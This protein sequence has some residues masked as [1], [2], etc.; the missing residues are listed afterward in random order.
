MDLKIKMM[1][2]LIE[3]D[4]DSFRKRAEMYFRKRPELM[5]LVEEF[6]RAYRALAERY[7]HAT[8]ALHQ[9]HRTMA[10]AFP[11]QIPLIL[12]DESPPGASSIDAEPHTLEMYSHS[13]AFKRNGVSSEETDATTSKEGSWRSTTEEEFANGWGRNGLPSQNAEGKSSREK[14]QQEVQKLSDENQ[15]LKNQIAH[16][17]ERADKAEAEVGNLKGTI[18]KLESEKEDVSLLYK[19]ALEKISH[20]TERANKAEAE[21]GYLKGTISKLNSEREDVS[22]QYNLAREMMSHEIERAD[23]AEAEVGYLKGTI[24]KLESEKED[25]S[26]QYQLALEKISS[27]EADISRVQGDFKKL[28]DEMLAGTSKSRSLEDRCHQLEIENQSLQLEL[29]VLKEMAKKQQDE[30]H[31]AQGEVEKLNISINEERERS[32]QAEMAC[33]SLE[34]L[35]SQSQEEVRGLS[36]EIQN[37]VEK[38]MN[39]ELS[40]VGLEEEI[41]QLKGEIDSLN[42]QICSSAL[43]IKSLQDEINLLEELK[44]KLQDEVGVHVD[45]KKS[46]QQEFLSIKADKKA[47]EQRHHELTEQIGAV[48]LN[49]ESLQGMV[50][51]LRDGNVEL[52]ELCEKHEDE[53][54]IY[55][56]S[57]KFMEKI[58]E[59]NVALENSLSNA[60]VELEEL[61]EKVKTLEES[62]EA[63][64]RKTSLHISEKAVIVSQIEAIARNM[65]KLSEKNTLLENSLSDVNVELEGLRSK[66]NVLEDTRQSLCGQNSSLLA[67]KSALITQVNISSTLLLIPFPYLATSI[68]FG[69]YFIISFNSPITS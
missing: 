62:C 50:K 30:L 53:R 58:T 68:K 5:R 21:V 16:E 29:S 61:R 4:A 57:L 46:L 3:E 11:D 41:Q 23:K 66:L 59:Q 34:K 48:N 20:E 42:E 39:V 33:L 10:E 8:G 31:M 12:L 51:E 9:A 32:M 43:K 2:K 54:V 13:T 7:D 52:K 40:K 45:E 64:R 36:L 35:H 65:E 49:V 22:L 18:S 26:L 15:N 1:I 55:L 69:S 63:L 24:P 28:N 38:L 47:L 44:R 37:W 14:V 56:K 17:T 60:N 27:L 67:E 19:L 6:Y 25:V